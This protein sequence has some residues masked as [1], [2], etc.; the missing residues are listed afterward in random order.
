MKKFGPDLPKNIISDPTGILKTPLMD[1]YAPTGYRVTVTERTINSGY[2]GD[3]RQANKY[4]KVGEIY[5]IEKT[6]VDKWTTDV[7]LKEIPGQIF[8]SVHFVPIT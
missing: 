8:N 3:A 1:I 6:E 4:L 7:W 5:T 2:D